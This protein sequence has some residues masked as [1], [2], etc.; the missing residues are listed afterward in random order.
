MIIFVTLAQVTAGNHRLCRE[1]RLCLSPKTSLQVA[2]EIKQTPFKKVELPDRLLVLLAY[3]A[4]SQKKEKKEYE[5]I[6]QKWGQEKLT[7]VALGCGAWG[8]EVAWLRQNGIEAWGIDVMA[9]EKNKPGLI[10]GRAED[11]KELLE[12]KGIK[13]ADLFISCAFFNEDAQFYWKNEKYWESMGQIASGI[14]SLLSPDGKL[15]FLTDHSYINLSARRSEAGKHLQQLIDV[16]KERG[17][18]LGYMIDPETEKPFSESAGV[19]LLVGT[20]I[21]DFT[22]STLGQSEKAVQ[23]QI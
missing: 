20:K 1:N 19:G 11:L 23:T 16:F 2:A 6:V 14:Q 12:K 4:D 15:L 21:K 7:V 9:Y 18:K 5:E 13:K 3:F 22:L 17:I 10:N 8:E